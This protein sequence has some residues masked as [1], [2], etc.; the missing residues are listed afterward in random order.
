LQARGLTSVEWKSI[1]D[2]FKAVSGQWQTFTFL[3]PAGNLL[4]NSEDFATA[5]WTNG[6]L[7][8]F[9]PGMADPLGTTRATR[10]VNAGQSAAAMAETLQ[11]P[12]NFVYCVSVW[13]RTD[14]G[15]EARLLPTAEAFA[16]GTEWRRISTRVDLGQ[17][18]TGITFGVQLNPGASMDL[19][20]MQ[21][22]AQLAASDYK[23]TGSTGG[24]RVARF[25]KDAL[26]VRAQ[27]T[28]VYDVTVR[29]VSA[30]S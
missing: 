29:I 21:V 18:G 9:T 5:T 25:A 7:L 24:V 2:L 14:A 3:D 17:N 10:I 12:Q 15:S 20:G 27:S 19:F 4:A 23:K 1:E 22:E 26:T 30:G 8:Q 11:V 16:L 28:D 6:P 13:A